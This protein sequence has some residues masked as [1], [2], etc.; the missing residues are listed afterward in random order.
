[1]FGFTST[2]LQHLKF[3]AIVLLAVISVSCATDM[4][5][6]KASAN[7]VEVERGNFD[8]VLMQPG[9]SLPPIR[10]ISIAEPVVVM[11][12]YWLRD[13]RSE[14]SERDL[15]RIKEDYGRFLK[16]TL[17]KTLTERTNVEVVEAASEADVVLRP[18]LLNLNIYGPDLSFR[19][20]TDNYIEAAGNATLN[21]EFVDPTGDEVL[22][23]FVDHRETPPIV[24]G[25]LE[26][27]NRATNNRLFMRLMTRWS[28]NLVDYLDD[29]DLVERR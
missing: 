4:R 7:L 18:S 22:A 24:M 2:I 27:T 15:K 28:L 11:S 3:A 17:A 23:Q 19:G 21:L 16:E 5:T 8:H 10:R 29:R 20:L 13:N 14:Y 26:E 12:D 6:E 1:M 9:S 25:R